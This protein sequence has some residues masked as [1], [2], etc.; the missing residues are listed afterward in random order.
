[1]GAGRR[2]IVSCRVAGAEL[3][4]FGS[5]DGRIGKAH[6]HVIAGRTELLEVAGLVVLEESLEV[7]AAIQGIGLQPLFTAR[8][9]VGR[10]RGDDA[11]ASGRQVRNDRLTT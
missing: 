7:L 10:R 2:D 1:M 4:P 3:G 11:V 5:N 6:R 8:N 9:T